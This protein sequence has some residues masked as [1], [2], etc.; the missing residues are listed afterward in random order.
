MQQQKIQ[1][2]VKLSAGKSGA[3][4]HGAEVHVFMQNQ[5]SVVTRCCCGCCCGAART[6]RP[7]NKLSTYT[8]V[9]TDIHTY[10]CI[11]IFVQFHY[12]KSGKFAQQQF[13]LQIKFRNLNL[14]TSS[15]PFITVKVFQLEF[16]I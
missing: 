13:S 3:G 4:E 15:T 16:F 1:R 12:E 8:Y 14:H 7:L 2:T 5:E 11:C 10:L 9:Y 6:L